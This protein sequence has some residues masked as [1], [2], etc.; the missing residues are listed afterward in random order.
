MSETNEDLK[1]PP[2]R[3][4]HKRERIHTHRTEKAKARKRVKM[5]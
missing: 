4:R 1:K 3:I 2:R 5:E